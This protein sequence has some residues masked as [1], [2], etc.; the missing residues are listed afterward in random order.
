[1]KWTLWFR[2]F[3]T[4]GSSFHRGCNY[5]HCLIEKVHSKVYFLYFSMGFMWFGF[6]PTKNM[7]FMTLWTNISSFDKKN[8][9]NWVKEWFK[10]DFTVTFINVSDVCNLHWGWFHEKFHDVELWIFK[11]L[12]SR[13]IHETVFF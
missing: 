10:L 1:M 13:K 5:F 6:K 9:R 4:C 7:I 2:G 11:K 8:P 3:W 12:I